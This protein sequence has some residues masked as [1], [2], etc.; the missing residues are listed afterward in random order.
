[1]DLVVTRW[2]EITQYKQGS[3]VDNESPYNFFVCF[4]FFIF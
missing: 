4:Y 1:M 2:T 3:V